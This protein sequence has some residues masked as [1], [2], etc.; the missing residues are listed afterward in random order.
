VGGEVLPLF[1]RSRECVSIDHDG[2][3]EIRSQTVSKE[4]HERGCIIVGLGRLIVES[5][6]IVLCRLSSLGESVKTIYHELILI[7]R[8]KFR[9]EVSLKVCPGV[10]GC[11][12][13]E[14]GGGAVILSMSAPAHVPAVP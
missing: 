1:E 9:A 6:G 11:L 7:G 13:V 2:I 14:V 4:F 8:E 12:V 3:L 5:N 10:G